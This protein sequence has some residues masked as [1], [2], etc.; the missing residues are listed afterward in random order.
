M[1]VDQGANWASLG[2][3][4]VVMSRDSQHTFVDR[5]HEEAEA[6]Q[7]CRRARSARLSLERDETAGLMKVGCPPG[8]EG[9]TWHPDDEDHRKACA[10][11]THMCWKHHSEICSRMEGL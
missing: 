10:C 1:E 11:S 8:W 9:H 4:S 6:A 3:A 5:P 7:A 2:G